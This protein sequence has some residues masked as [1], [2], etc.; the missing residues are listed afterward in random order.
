MDCAGDSAGHNAVGLGHHVDHAALGDV[1][2]CDLRDFYGR[3]R[4]AA[5]PS[6]FR[7]ADRLI[8]RRA[9]GLLARWAPRPYQFASG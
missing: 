1:G 8:A 5:H 2:T 7:R 9:L 3:P 6:L 4:A